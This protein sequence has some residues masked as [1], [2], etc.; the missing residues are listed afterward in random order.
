MLVSPRDIFLPWETVS[1]P[2]ANNTETHII[3]M[4]KTA[5]RFHGCAVIRWASVN[6]GTVKSCSRGKCSESYSSI[7]FTGTNI[8]DWFIRNGWPM[9]S[10]SLFGMIPPVTN[11]LIIIY[12][13][14]LN[15]S[16][17]TNV[18]KTTTLGGP[19]SY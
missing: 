8:P 11:E 12:E 6:G 9:R 3:A 18:S 4:N 15:G 2:R 17:I 13:L 1:V 7:T 19:C 5:F 16:N 14:L 10:G